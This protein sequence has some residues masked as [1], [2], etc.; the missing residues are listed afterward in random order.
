MTIPPA[1]V[2]RQGFRQE[3]KLRIG[4][5]HSGDLP[6][7]TQ[8]PSTSGLPGMGVAAPP[9]PGVP[10]AHL[11]LGVHGEAQQPVVHL[12]GHREAP[13]LQVLLPQKGGQTGEDLRGEAETLSSTCFS[14]VGDS[15]GSPGLRKM[16]KGFLR[17]HR[18]PTPLPGSVKA[19]A[20]S[21][22]L[23]KIAEGHPDPDTDPSEGRGGATNG[24]G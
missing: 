8:Q 5:Q 12:Q 19:L 6:G 22:G 10:Q 15:P 24:L 23:W 13:G 3:Q 18:V 2:S 1:G 17:V 16:P 7:P 20:K 4:V 21:G 9:T 14:H 11:G